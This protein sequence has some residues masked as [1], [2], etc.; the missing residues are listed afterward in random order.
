MPRRAAY[1][2]FCGTVTGRAPAGALELV[3]PSRE[4]MPLAGVLTIGRASDS[5]VSLDDRSVSRRHAR[6]L[7]GGGTP[8][9]EDVGST[10]G[11]LLDG[12]PIAGP[13]ALFDGAVIRLGDVELRVERAR[14]EA[15]AG[16]TVMVPAAQGTMALPRVE[17]PGTQMGF[18][19]GVRPGWALKRL[20]ASEGSRRFVLRNLRTGDLVRMGPEEAELFELLDGHRAL[21]ELMTEAEERQGAAGVPRLAQLLAE[22]G[23]RGLLEGVDGGGP[24]PEQGGRLRSLLKPRER[25]IPGA[26]RLFERIYLA[27][28][29]ILFTGPALLLLAVL[30]I[31]GLVA[32]G[33]LIF[34]RY[35]TPFVVA[36]KIGLGGLVFIAGRFLVVALHEVAHGLVVASFGRSVPRAGIKVMMGMPFAFVDTSEAWF[37][38]RRRRIAISA[39]GPASDLVVGGVVALV[40]LALSPGNFRDILFQVA[41]AAYIGAF[42]NLNPFLDRDGYHMLVDALGQPGLRRKARDYLAL[43][44]AGKPT[45]AVPRSL[46]VYAVMSVGWMLLAIV[47]VVVLSQ[48]YFDRLN[49]IAPA[50]AVWAVFG[51]LYLLLFLPIAFV[52][53]RPLLERRRRAAPE[54][55]G[56]ALA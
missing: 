27:G 10:Y 30:A 52:L 24:A 44:L 3:L 7:A 15:E 39:A 32:F 31:G 38:P 53:G 55:A 2:G 8:L 48:L 9:I 56:G 36:D 45:P 22:L 33:V 26:G 23:E 13:A 18:R 20:E 28:G 41:L 6:I 46:A 17:A 40:A 4:R 49:A 47:F 21:P 16:R 25:V 54:E 43:R 34:G 29:W 42:F 50:W 12:A 37:E 11:T 1:C 19:P 5:T 14:A 35:G 51:G